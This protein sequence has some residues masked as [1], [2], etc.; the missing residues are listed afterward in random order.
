M[1]QSS[2]VSAGQ[3]ATATQYNNLR[4]DVF[5]AHHQD[6]AGVKIVNADIDSAAAI[7][8]SKLVALTASRA[9]VTDG[10]GII[11][12]S[13]VTATELGYL[14]GITSKPVANSGDETING[15]KTFGSIPLLPASN[16]TADNQAARKK[17]VD[18]KT[19]S[20]SFTIGICAALERQGVP[21]EDVNED[22]TITIGF[23]AR[24][25]KLYFWIEGYAGGMGQS[26][27]KGMAWFNNGSLVASFAIWGKV[28]NTNQAP[29][30]Y[31]DWM[32]S[33]YNN[34]Y[35]NGAFALVDDASAIYA[36][37]LGSNNGSRID[38][39]IVNITSTAFTVRKRVRGMTYNAGKVKFHAVY[40]AYQ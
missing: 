2:N 14:S 4:A 16:P 31:G 36:G 6:P 34:P 22:D 29:S 35:Y 7:A 24:I 1:A 32:S 26:G 40:E 9:L 15:I 37:T 30:N 5:S 23:Q 28:G 17:F 3:D 12:V 39:S 13:V 8:L 21:N 27:Y 10:S 19:G 33:D 38:L 20:K 25:I 18:D 11:T